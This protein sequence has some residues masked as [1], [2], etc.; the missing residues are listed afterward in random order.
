MV[1]F[2]EQTAQVQQIVEAAVRY[3]ICLIPYG[4][5][6]NVSYALRC[7]EYEKRMI[8]SVDMSRMNKIRW[9]DRENWLACI[10]AGAVGRQIES[11]LTMNEFIIGHEPDSVEFSTLGGRIATKDSGMEKNKYGNIEDI[12]LDVE[13]VAP[14]GLLIQLAEAVSRESAG[15]VPRALIF[16]SEGNL[17]IITAAVVKLHPVPATQQYGSVV[18][19][20]FEDGF[21]FM[22]EV[23]RRSTTGQCAAS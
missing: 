13:A 7:P 6:T 23:T 10:E 18:F 14:S 12:A 8:I 1:V 16:G 17:C 2:P 5:G 15:F 20:S 4:G 11:N 21:K 3:D 19:P 9:I 22:Y